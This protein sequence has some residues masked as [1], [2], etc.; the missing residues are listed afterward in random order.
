MLIRCPIF[1]SDRVYFEFVSL[2]ATVVFWHFV[3]GTGDVRGFTR[4]Q[5]AARRAYHETIL[6]LCSAGF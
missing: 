2:N 6:A 4:E 5:N 3:L 1:I